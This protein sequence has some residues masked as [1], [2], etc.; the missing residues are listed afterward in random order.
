MEWWSS[1]VMKGPIQ[2]RFGLSFLPT[3][4]YS[5]TPKEFA[6]VPAKPLNSHLALKTSFTMLNKYI[7]HSM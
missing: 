3:L 5:S 6:P 1:G 2:A 4:Q 7:S